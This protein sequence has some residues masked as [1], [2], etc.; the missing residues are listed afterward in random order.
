MLDTSGVGI[1][2][3]GLSAARLT[4]TLAPKGGEREA[5]GVGKASDQRCSD[6]PSSAVQR[7]PAE[8][9]HH[10]GRNCILM[11][12]RGGV[13]AHQRHSPKQSPDPAPEMMQGTLSVARDSVKLATCKGG[14]W[15]FPPAQRSID[16]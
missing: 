13:M 3:P 11:K 8:G 16:A 10:P 15:A 2:A 9:P 1:T 12:V 7:S 14:T 4:Q 5:L 6:H